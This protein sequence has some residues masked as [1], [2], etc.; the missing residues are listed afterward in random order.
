MSKTVEERRAWAREYH[1]QRYQEDPEYRET[2][3]KRATAWNRVN[4]EKV[5]VFVKNWRIANV[6]RD[7]A[8]RN[9]IQKLR[10]ARN[11][12]WNKLKKLAN[13]HGCLPVLLL[14]VEFRDN[15]ECQSCDTNEDLTF[16]HILPVSKGGQTTFDNLQ[17]LCRSCNSAKGA[18]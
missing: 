4:K 10:V 3:K 14:H 17:L 8:N 9:R 7:R 16:D 11:P 5:A 15:Y 18:K 13:S 1:K 12:E 6:E 2:L